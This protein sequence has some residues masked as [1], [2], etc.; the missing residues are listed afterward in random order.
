MGSLRASNPRV[1]RGILGISCLKADLPRSK[2]P[3][4]KQAVTHVQQ[5]HAHQLLQIT[6]AQKSGQINYFTRGAG[7]SCTRRPHSLEAAISSRE[8]VKFCRRSS[9]SQIHVFSPRFF[10]QP[11]PAVGGLRL[12]VQYVH[13]L[14][15]GL[16]VR[17]SSAEQEIIA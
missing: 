17:V 8:F 14:F 2:S 11:P 1:T 5:P 10:R 3:A 15:L 12:T 13:S 16:T 7:K 6:S 9:D 4:W